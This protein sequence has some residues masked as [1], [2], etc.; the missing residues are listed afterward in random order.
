MR[1]INSEKNDLFA[2]IVRLDLSG[3]HAPTAY[4]N[5][6]SIVQ[7]QGDWITDV[8]KKMREQGKT[9]INATKEAEEEWKDR[10]NKMHE[11][12]LRHNI[13]SWY[14]GTVSSIDYEAFRYRC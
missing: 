10:V 5:G 12:T 14:M 6:P 13:D 8:T 1:S 4:G 3:P 2:D 7:P 11:P 9:K